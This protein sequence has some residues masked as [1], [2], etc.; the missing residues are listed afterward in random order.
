MTILDDVESIRKADPSNMYN[1]IFDLPEQMADA[2]TLAQR[3][4][5]DPDDFSGIKNIVVIGMGGS[6][7]GGDLTRTYLS[8]KLLVP[9]E[10][11]RHYVLPEYVDDET[12]VI[13][14]SYSGNTEETMS[15]VEDALSRKA[16]M[17]AIS[18]GGLLGEICELNQI[19]LATLPEG[20]QPRAAIG[21][22]FIPLVMFLEK[23]GLAKDVAKE[24]ETVVDSLQKFR[25]GYI[26]D[27]PVEQNP[28]KKLAQKAHGRIPI[29]YSGPTLMDAVAVRFK[30][31]L[32]ENGKNLAFANHFAEFNHNELVGWSK[33]IEPF[34]DKLLVIMLRDAGD[35]PQIRKRMNIVKEHIQS[36]D[37]ELVEVHSKGAVRLERMFSLIQIGDFTSYYLAVLNEVD[38]TPVE[39]IQDLKN[40]L[41]MDKVM[42]T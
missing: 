3:W 13:A 35:H 18:T 4:Q 10:I 1:R 14:S 27:Q 29:V 21:Y 23:I 31:Q 2:L 8:S 32:C 26:E 25:D 36:L 7:I 42:T 33:T 5:I 20:L 24:L 17:V 40:A 30:G 39:V 28:A 16:M 38:P 37:V 6:A 9:F 41:E 34:K 11:C 15:A 19:P 22:S 12:L